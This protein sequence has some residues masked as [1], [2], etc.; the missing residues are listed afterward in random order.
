MN[1]YVATALGGLVGAALGGFAGGLLASFGG[2]GGL[3]DL[4]IALL[5]VLFGV[6]LGAAMGSGV[7]LRIAGKSRVLLTSG[8]ALFAMFGA[9]IGGLRLAGSLEPV[10]LGW[11]TL[12]AAAILALLAARWVA[13]R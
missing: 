7:A 13:T 1:D 9:F 10:A 5:G 11:V 12:I 4:G 8:L 2:D 3:E 6:S